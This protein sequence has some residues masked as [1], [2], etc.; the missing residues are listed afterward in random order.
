[1]EEFYAAMIV[2][3]YMRCYDVNEDKVPQTIYNTMKSFGVFEIDKSPENKDKGFY[4]VPTRYC[5]LNPSRHWGLVKEG[6]SNSIC[7]SRRM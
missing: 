1:M 7:F 6:F 4:G 3:L 2:P 5:G